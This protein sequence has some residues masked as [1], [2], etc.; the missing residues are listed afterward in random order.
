MQI[1]VDRL[2]E[3]LKLLQPVVPKKPTLAVLTSVLLRDG[4]AVATDLE[5]T[6]ILDA[7]EVEGEYLIPHQ[8]V[9]ELLKYVPGNELLTIE[10]EGKS[11]HLTWNGGKADYDASEPKDYPPVPEPETRAEG[12]FDG[13][14]LVA[15]LTS[16][17]GYCATDQARPVLSGVTLVLG[18]TI[19]AAA[20]DGFRM[21]Y[22]TLP[23]SLPVEETVIVPTGF[24]RLLAHLWS[25]A[26]P[27]VPMESSLV[28]QITA[29]RELELA[30]SDGILTA[31]F[32]KV[33]LIG[34]LIEGTPP[35]WIQLIP[36]ETPLKVRVFASDLE[37]AV[38]R[39]QGI[40]KDGTGIVRL[41]WTENALTVS[42][43]SADKGGVEAEVAIQTEG[44]P[45]RIAINVS[46]LLSYL[47]GREG[48]LT[49]C[50]RNES[51]PILL[52]HGTSPWVVIM[53]MMVQW[54]PGV[55]GEEAEAEGE[56][57]KAEVEEA[58]EPKEPAEP[59]AP[60][61]VKPKKQRHRK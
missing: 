58:E 53:P 2:R 42:A 21:A 17:A 37:R 19:E 9:L 11:L 47:K 25:K 39:L 14:H 12:K 59:E 24:I 27:A 30:L 10:S 33:T 46:Y 55:E 52:R 50:A 5:E 1:R 45:G 18:E 38:H 6:I 57:P 34:K 28:R 54:E 22:Q 48:L 7:P 43:R 44:G 32:G 40:A 26:P 31:R 20:G 15:V 36:Q 60:P 51:S 56:E 49:M 4:Q 13:D 61:E 16:V 3:D 8:P 41:V 29:K 35:S 23:S